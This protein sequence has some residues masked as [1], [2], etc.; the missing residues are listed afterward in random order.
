MGR[1]VIYFKQQVG[2]VAVAAAANICC[3]IPPVT[4]REGDH[5]GPGVQMTKPKPRSEMICPRSRSWYRT[6][7]R[8]DL[9]PLWAS[10]CLLCPV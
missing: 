1:N 5:D 2:G 4:P 10:C 7:L 3:V 8:A 9:R 6:E